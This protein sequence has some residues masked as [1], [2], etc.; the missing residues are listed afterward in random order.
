MKYGEPWQWS[1]PTPTAASAGVVA[2]LKTALESSVDSARGALSSLGD[3]WN[4]LVSSAVPKMTGASGGGAVDLIKAEE[5]LK[6]KIAASMDL[7]P[8]TVQID[9]SSPFITVREQLVDLLSNIP[10]ELNI[11]TSGFRE[12]TLATLDFYNWL[13]SVYPIPNKAEIKNALVFLAQADAAA[14]AL[15]LV[16]GGIFVYSLTKGFGKGK[17]S[18]D[19]GPPPRYNITDYER[20]FAQRRDVVTDRVTELL[21]RGGGLAWKIWRDTKGRDYETNEPKRAQELRELITDLGP[22]F[23]K[24]GQGVSVRPDL[25]SE[26]Y[27]RELQKLQ[28][29]VP[30][31][32]ADEAKQV[33]LKELQAAGGSPDQTLEDY[34]E[35]VSVFDEPVAAASLGQVYKAKWKRTGKTVA[36]KIQRPDLLAK[37]SLD[38]FVIRKALSLGAA[39]SFLPKRTRDSCRSFGKVIDNA[40]ARFIEELD[41]MKEA[42]NQRRFKEEVEANALLDGS[43]VVP[44]VVKASQFVL[45]TEWIDGQKL[46]DLSI[47]EDDTPATK[48][49]KEVVLEKVVKSLLNCYLVQLL[50]TGWLHADP[51]PGNFLRT[52]DGRLCVLD[53]GLMTEIKPDQRVALVEYVA[54]LSAR[55]YDKALN[56]LITL[57]FIP[58]E[59]GADPEK[60][61]IVV[62]LLSNVLGQLANG[63]GASG[64]NVESVGR[65]V[66]ELSK[67][68]PIS[69]PSYF[70]LIVRAFGTLEGLGLGLDKQFSILSECLPYLAKR[71]LTD[72]SPRVREALRSFLY[73]KQNYLDPERVNQI[74]QG[75]TSFT[76]DVTDPSTFLGAGLSEEQQE[77]VLTATGQRARPPPGSP[78]ARASETLA[79]R[80]AAFQVDET[81]KEL[82]E[83]LL[84]PEGNFVQDLVLDEAVRLTDAVTRT[85]AGGAARAV[86]SATDSI[87]QQ[88]TN[89]SPAALFLL[90]I[91]PQAT[92][93]NAISRS[94]EELNQPTE[95]DAKTIQTAQQVLRAIAPNA[96]TTSLR[97]QLAPTALRNFQPAEDDDRRR[98]D[99]RN[100]RP[101]F[102][103]TLERARERRR[104]RRRLALAQLNALQEVSRVL[105][106]LSPGITT[107]VDKFARKLTRRVLQ[108]LA[109]D[110]LAGKEEGKR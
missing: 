23:I 108:R 13:W 105:N 33:L 87:Q 100:R 12:T 22:A 99:G 58:P 94:V 27:L 85:T 24:I 65:D 98:A 72:D 49:D 71:L 95:E 18:A 110:L 9:P 60:R 106:D 35:D 2:Q 41:Y 32:G 79:N 48:A 102:V 44:G 15:D 82:L 45:V 66:E 5:A 10:P 83:I 6:Q 42:A 54:H 38:L 17:L 78:Q 16:L 101:T 61:A 93:A 29:R 30:P 51:H 7:D 74:L 52:A 84:A 89:L 91:L 103:Q 21:W 80:L 55:D 36:V 3:S 77:Q 50:E 69:I 97:R 46:T 75:Y 104:E 68:Y 39:A 107:V 64:I 76:L 90:P 1:S 62:P 96:L 8:S 28:D 31:F 47:K 67:Q 92:V 11:D 25:L 86:R 4:A 26:T 56:D 70:G 43:I 40:G 34:F 57:G 59:I 14:V 63:G 109:N 53:F 19:D 81:T 37:C 20:F 73:G 88:F